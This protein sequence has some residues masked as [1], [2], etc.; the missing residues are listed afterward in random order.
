LAGWETDQTSGAKS[1]RENE[2]GCRIGLM[3]ALFDK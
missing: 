1:R 2:I 3:I